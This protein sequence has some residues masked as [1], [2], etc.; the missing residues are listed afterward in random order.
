[1]TTSLNAFKKLTKCLR[2][3]CHAAFLAVFLCVA[4]ICEV[5]ADDDYAGSARFN[6]M[7]PD[8]ANLSVEV[9]YSLLTS[10]IESER[11]KVECYLLGVLDTTERSNLVR[12]C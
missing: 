3:A 4:V 7:T 12:S 9:F 6:S 8:S 5:S 10:P 11:Q 1:V 2:P